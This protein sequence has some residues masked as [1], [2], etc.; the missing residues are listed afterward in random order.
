M[1]KLAGDIRFLKLDLPLGS[2]ARRHRSLP[3]YVPAV[4][5][6]QDVCWWMQAGGGIQSG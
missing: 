6:F 2:R 4:V 1:E 5:K 3:A